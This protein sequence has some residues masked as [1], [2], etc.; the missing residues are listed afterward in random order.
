MR[1]L[2]GPG[3]VKQIGVLNDQRA[4]KIALRKQRLDSLRPRVEFGFGCVCHNQRM[5]A[6]G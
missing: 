4:V 1:L 2:S 3:K 5:K 6:E